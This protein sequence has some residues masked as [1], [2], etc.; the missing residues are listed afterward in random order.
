MA[1]SIAQMSTKPSA[2]IVTP[3]DKGRKSIKSGK[4]FLE[5]KEEFEIEL[6]NPLTVSVLSDIKLNGQSI[7]KTGLVLK[8]GQR[9]YLD[10]FIDDKK[11]FIFSTYEI[12]GGQESL[13]AT[14]N[15][16]LLEVFFYKEDVITLD[17]WRSR[18]DR[19]IVEKYYPVYY[20]NTYPWNNIYCGGSF[21]TG[22]TTTLTNGIIGT[23]TTTINA[24]YPSNSNVNCS[25]TSNVDLS[26]SNMTSINSIETGRVEKGEV[27]KQKFTEIE[28]DFE[29]NYISST[30]IQILPESRKP[31]ETKEIKN[32]INAKDILIRESDEVITL[33]KKL[34]DLHSAGILTDEEF[35]NK[36]TELL[37]K[38]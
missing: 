1:K 15:N 9:V 10:C 30:I 12:D 13:D 36:K 22:G 21:G 3:N 5:D 20:P 16:G 26:N 27:S 7:S 34:A 38:I 37:S 32:K 2:W 35:S 11:K 23:T 14:Q 24:Y 18:F 17:N 19:V 6:F 29:K 4:V 28:M 31:V 25:Y 33:I 8:P